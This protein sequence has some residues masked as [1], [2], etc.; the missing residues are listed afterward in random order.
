MFDGKELT[1]LGNKDRTAL[2]GTDIAYIPQEPMSNLD[3]SFRIGQQLTVPMRTK[4]GLSKQ[5]AT[6]RALA[7]LAK[8]G[9]ADPE[10]TFKSYPHEVSG[11]MA[12]RVLIAGAVS[13]NPRL[14]IADEPTT[15]L[16]VT[17]Q[18]QVMELLCELNERQGSAVL[19]I[20]H[21]ISLLSEVCDR[22]LVM[23][24]G[25]LVEDLTVD[26]LLAGPEHPYTQAL[27]RAVPDLSTDRSRELATIP[28]GLDA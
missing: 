15:A 16:D 19:I 12:Q 5:E 22:I 13:C 4:L 10:K 23:W 2:R 27:V 14:L 3:P 21:N 24:R 11:G 28:E 25:H 17:V 1:A 6:R 9:I 20:S 18:A 7:L 8:V 26:A